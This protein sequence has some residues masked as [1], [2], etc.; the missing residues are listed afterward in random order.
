MA[1]TICVIFNTHCG[2]R[3]LVVTFK[4]WVKKKYGVRGVAKAAQFLGYPYKSVIAWVNLNRFP[5]PTAQEV[6]KLKSEG[7]IDMEAWRTAYLAAEIE[8]KKS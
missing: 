1:I 5:R 8:R 6:I 4:E 7:D 2:T 3:G